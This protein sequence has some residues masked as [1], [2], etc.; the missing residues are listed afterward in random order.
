MNTH[1]GC[2][3]KVVDFLDLIML[4]VSLTLYFCTERPWYALRWRSDFHVTHP[5][6]PL[7]DKPINISMEGNLYFDIKQTAACFGF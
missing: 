5:V 1:T 7:Y 4:L 3:S 6:V 2:R